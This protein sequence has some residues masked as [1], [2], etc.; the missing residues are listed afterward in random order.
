M[1]MISGLTPISGNLSRY[2]HVDLDLDL[3]V[4]LDL[5]V[6]VIDTFS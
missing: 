4:G 1:F 2:P 3:D 5:D 6:F